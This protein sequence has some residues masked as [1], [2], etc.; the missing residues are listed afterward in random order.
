LNMEIN[1][2]I[3]VTYRGGLK[4]MKRWMSIV[5]FCAALPL[6]AGAGEKLRVGDPAPDFTLPAATQDTIEFRGIH[7]SAAEGN[8]DIILAFYPADWSGGCTKEMCTMRDNF[9]DL[10]GLGATVYGISG[11][12]VFS[13][14]QWAK[15]LGL[16]F[17][18]L[19]DHDH[20]VARLYASYNEQSGFNQRTV[21]VIDRK[22]K[23]AYADPAYVAGSEDSFAKLKNALAA[24][25][26]QEAR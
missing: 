16:P 9:R 1:R 25:H 24:I 18:L 15:A 14:R 5:A 23:I 12:Y 2:A 7:L 4:L 22:G 20:R 21:Y 6:I 3:L 11:D 26:G 10:G 19:S 17:T 13:H 8:E